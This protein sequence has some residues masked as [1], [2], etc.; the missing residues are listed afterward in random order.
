ASFADDDLVA[1]V[2]SVPFAEQIAASGATP[3]SSMG[4]TMRA[5]LPGNIDQSQTN[6]TLIDDGQLEWVVPLDGTVLDSRAVSV[7]SPGDDRWWALP[8]SVLALVALIAWAVFMTL[9][10][11]YVAWARW[12]RTH[13]R[14]PPARPAP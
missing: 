4:V 13:R 12:Q 6:G 9:F 11:G 8:L 5:A 3:A 10:I 2:G 14:R 7:Q 1:A